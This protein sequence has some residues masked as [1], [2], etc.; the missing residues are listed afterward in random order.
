MASNK[1]ITDLDEISSITVADDDVLAIVDVS[2]NK[3]Y[4]IRKDAFEVAISGVTSMAAGS[5]LSTNASTGAVVLTLGTVP[6][7]KGGT[8]GITASEA[9][10]NLGLG[11]IATQNSNAISVTGGSAS[12]L[13]S[14][15][16]TTL[17][18]TGTSTL[19]TVDI[20]GGAIDGTTIGS[21][22]P[23]TAAFTTLTATGTS[24]LSTVDINAGAIDGTT[25]GATSPST[26]AFTTLSASS[27]YTGDVT[28]NIASSGTSTFATTTQSGTATFNNDVTFNSTYDMV[29][30]A[31]DNRLEFGDNAKASWG[32]SNDLEIFHDGA[33]TNIVEQGTGNLYILSTGGSIIF[34]TSSTDNSIVIDQDSAVRLYYDNNLQLETASWGVS[35]PGSMYATTV[36]GTTGNITTVNATDLNFSGS[37]KE[38][39][40]ALT[41]SFGT[42]T[43]YTLLPNGLKLNWGRVADTG[44]DMVITYPSAFSTKVYS[45]TLAQIDNAA[46]YQNM[47]IDTDYTSSLDHFDLTWD[48]GPAYVAYIAIGH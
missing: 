11:S 2:Q 17:S 13:T 36:A 7:N 31:S 35:I 6:V 25:I 37:L 27:G 45:I 38:D 33:N 16:T 10:T 20:N 1:K 47:T 4:K 15:G 3:T 48:S 43:G 44:T 32:T 22:S 21:S 39:G 14:V 40:T 18:A 29:W 19:S 23:S 24:T 5:P 9:R 46:N 34:R 42:D 28:G 26:G 12:G 30:D 41:S 8:G